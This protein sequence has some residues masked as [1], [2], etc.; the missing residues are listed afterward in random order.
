MDNTLQEIK[1]RLN[2]ADVIADYI[3]VKKAGSAFKAV[4]P[5]H[6]EKTP[7]LM[8]SPQKQIWHCF[9]CG[10]GGDIF[11]FVM[12]HENLEFKEA[13]KL[14]AQKA[15]VSLPEFKPKNPQEESE[16][17]LLYRIN[18][19]A[20]RYYHQVL[21]KDK[22][23]AQGLEYLKNRGLA[24]GTIKKWQIGFAPDDFHSLEQALLKK[25]VGVADLL[26]AGVSAKN[27]RGQIYDRFRNRVVFPIFDYQDRAVGFSARVLQGDD[28]SAKYINSPETLIYQKSRILFGLNFAKNE[29]RK[30]DEVVVVEGQMDCIAAHQAGFGNVV[31]S[32][33][34][35]LTQDQLSLLARLTKNIKFC[36]DADAAGQAASRRAG[37]LAL[38]QGFRLKVVN[39]KTAK[40]PDE[41][42]KKNPGLWGKAVKEAQWFLDWQMDFAQNHFVADVVE[43]KHFLSRNVVPLLGCVADPLEQDHYIRRMVERFGISEYTIRQEISRYLKG[44]APAS[45]AQEP[46]AFSDKV[47]GLEKEVLGG[48]LKFPDFARRVLAESSLEDFTDH[49][50]RAALKDF[51]GHAGQKQP[52]KSATVAKEA[53]FVVESLLDM[54]DND[55]GVVRRQLEKSFGFLAIQALKR[56]QQALILQIKLAEEAKDK[57][58]LAE[59]NQ[60]LAKLLEKRFVLEK[61]I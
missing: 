40:D 14:L 48:L 58:K 57:A 45:A 38:R 43:Q 1:D 50:I 15:G 60:Q 2:V 34:T 54:A 6:N 27:E 18:D 19:F 52:D 9:G 47:N 39:L 33:G 3:P 10:E 61:A 49:N 37:E 29:I 8:I 30:G 16:K 59:L 20:A 28:K 35:A 32:S 21:L 51:Y 22:R 17:D 26:K 13:L 4:C 25:K 41:L 46:K 56:K 23:G 36:F 53:M 44:Q 5:F 42:I 12:R 31:A 55:E 24:D 11:G 7:S